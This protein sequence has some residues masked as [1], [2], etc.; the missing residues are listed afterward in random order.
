MANKAP[1]TTASSTSSPTQQAAPTPVRP[2]GE[3][4]LHERQDL[5]PPMGKKAFEAL[6]D[7]IRE[8]GLQSPLAVTAEGVVL[9]GRARLAAA[10]L[11]SLEQVPV[12]LLQPTDEQDYMLSAALLRRHLSASQ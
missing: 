2:V 7:D 1:A 6:V 9:D 4:R 10:G 11:L 3:L 5:V 12:R 8:R